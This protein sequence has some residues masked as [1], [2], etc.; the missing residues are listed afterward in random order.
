MLCTPRRR[1]FTLIELLVVIAIIAV[2]VAILLPAVQ[3]AREAARASQCRNNLKQIGIALHN[4][5]ETA[6]QFP[7]ASFPQTGAVAGRVRSA[8]W[9]IRLF[10]YL[11]Q[12]TAFNKLVFEGADLTGQDGTDLNW[13]VR[14]DTRVAV[15]SCPSSLLPQTRSDGCTTATQ[16]LG[17]P[18]TIAVQVSSYAGVAGSYLNPVTNACCVTPSANTSYGYSAWNGIIVT[19]TQSATAGVDPVK[20]ATVA[21]GT[22]NT[23]AA[24]EQGIADP[25]CLY[26][27]KDCRA[28]GHAGG[29]WG[30]GTGEF[31]N[32]WAGVVVV[33]G[34]INSNVNPGGSEQPYYRHTKINSAHTGGAHALLTDGAVKF[35]SNSMSEFVLANASSRNDMVPIGDF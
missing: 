15:Y 19:P 17:A 24:V 22:S 25:T 3:Q 14:R 33:R 10:P 7:I 30:S 12:A 23:I 6:N 5:H 16:G 4:Y 21:D 35:L 1:G 28:S 18:A 32:W 26:A 8:S 20:I 2:L 13:M 9:L 29:M 27:G 34:G 11:D 31:N